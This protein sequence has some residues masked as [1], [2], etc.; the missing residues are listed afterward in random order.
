MEAGDGDKEVAAQ[1]IQGASTTAPQTQIQFAFTEDMQRQMQQI[2]K[3]FQQ[4]SP[5]AF[6]SYLQIFDGK[7][8]M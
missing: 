6:A 4:Q 7:K 2:V 1:K 8:G 5:D 3:Q